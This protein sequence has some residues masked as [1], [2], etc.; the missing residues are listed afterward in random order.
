[1][2]LENLP[3]SQL[4]KETEVELFIDNNFEIVIERMALEE[5]VQERESKM[6]DT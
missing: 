4:R 5:D 6:A 2:N 3:G 1:M